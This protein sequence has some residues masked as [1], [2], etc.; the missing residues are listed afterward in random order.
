MSL[1]HDISPLAVADDIQLMVETSSKIEENLVLSRNVLQTRYFAPDVADD[2]Q[3]MVDTS[4]KIEENLVLS[5]NVPQ[6]RYF[7]P[8]SGGRY[9]ANG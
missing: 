2:I 8:D 1:K 3:L 9:S 5:R 4:S 6:T 7:T